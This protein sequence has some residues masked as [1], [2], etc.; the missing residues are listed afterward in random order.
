MDVSQAYILVSI[1]ILLVIA[2]VVF[3]VRGRKRERLTPMAAFAF[4]FVIGGIAFGDNRLVGY[5]L[6][7]IGVLLAVVDILRKLNK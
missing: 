6:I 4:A 2:V 1:V 3:F 5:G 7:G